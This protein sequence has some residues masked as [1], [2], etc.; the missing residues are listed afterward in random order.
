MTTITNIDTKEL[1]D[2]MN[3]LIRNN[4]YSKIS[5]VFKEDLEV[6]KLNLN[7]QLTNVNETL[8]SIRENL[9]TQQE[10]IK[11]LKIR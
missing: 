10:N 2:I 11:R 6:P 3:D 4:N 8:S 1:Q 9:V 5:V 7:N